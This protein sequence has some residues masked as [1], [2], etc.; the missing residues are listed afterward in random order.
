MENN[1]T[2][3]ELRYRLLFYANVK[4]EKKFF[5]SSC[6]GF[7]KEHFEVLLDTHQY[8]IEKFEEEFAKKIEEF[9]NTKIPIPPRPLLIDGTP[10]TNN[11]TSII[12]I[13]DDEIPF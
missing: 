8:N 5:V 4:G 3:R 6:L 1:N 12:N 10:N 11:D 9:R 7:S 13:D 2:E